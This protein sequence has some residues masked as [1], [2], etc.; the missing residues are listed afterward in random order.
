MR[1]RRSTSTPVSA[2]SLRDGA[3]EVVCSA[4][5]GT[6]RRAQRADSKNGQ[7]RIAHLYGGQPI[8]VPTQC[9]PRT[10]ALPGNHE[11]IDA[12]LNLPINQSTIHNPQSAIQM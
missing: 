6:T 12:S 9:P 1:A 4:P 11:I 2:L 8:A 7:F 3:P 5:A 10:P